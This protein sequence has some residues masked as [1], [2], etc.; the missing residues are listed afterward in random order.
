MNPLY[1]S[2]WAV[3]VFLL[4]TFISAQEMDNTVEETPPPEE[5]TAVKAPPASR[6][7]GM[8]R[9]FY[10]SN[11]DIRTA[12]KAVGAAGRVDI[13]L[14]PNIKGRVNLTL[15]SK[16]WKQTMKIL[17]QMFNLQYTVENGYIYIQSIKEFN[18]TEKE[19]RLIRKIIHLKHT[20]VNDLKTAIQGLLSKRGK[21]TVVDKSNAIIITDVPLKIDEIKKTIF[22]LD[23]ETYQVHIQAQIIEVNSNALQELG[24]NWGAGVGTPA[25]NVDDIPSTEQS[26][27]IL[28]RS[29]PGRILNSSFSLAFRLLDGSL[30]AAFEGLLSEGKGEVV[31]KP[32][33]TT[34]DNTEARIF[35]GE[36][37]PFN[38]M[39]ANLNTTTEFVDAGVELIVTPHITNNK[40][41]ILDLAPQRS[42]AQTDPI[43]R[44]PIVTTTE[45]RTTVV[46]D[47][48]E[49]VVIGGLTSKVEDETESGIP[50]LK[51]IPLLG[52][53]FKRT[54]KKVEKK[55]LIIFITP[56]IV[57]KEPSETRAEVAPSN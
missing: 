19:A 28:G 21:L 2:K 16:T 11:L 34:L 9:D 6:A 1:L 42:E 32:Q 53:F 15:T 29:S 50:F 48:G 47:D 20:K 18:E 25:P 35:I 40:R 31:A 54:S 44:G 38:K 33:I 7:R 39:D 8:L 13:V 3:I 5:M 30:G 43:T 51:D 46:V 57:K 4:I 17:C 24:I 41:I 10:F 27:A 56:F 22:V 23:V 36:R 52:F 14:S 45:A 12:F 55:D 37:R 26:G 49:T